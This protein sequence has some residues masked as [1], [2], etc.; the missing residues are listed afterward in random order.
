M[1]LRTSLLATTAGFVFIIATHQAMADATI[2]VT[3][4][5]EE[6]CLFTTSQIDIAFGVYDDTFDSEVGQFAFD[7]P[8][9][10]SLTFSISGGTPHGLNDGSFEL[11]HNNVGLNSNPLRF[12]IKDPDGTLWTNGYTT[13]SAGG[14]QT[15]DFTAELP[16]S[17]LSNDP[18]ILPGDFSEVLTMTM[19]VN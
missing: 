2:N 19:T 11:P 16:P 6:E 4:T 13:A 5:V 7:C 18:S 9:G 12:F 8:S 3:A 17:Q 10:K 14:P 1:T 15:R